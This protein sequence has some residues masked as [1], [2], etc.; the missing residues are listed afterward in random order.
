MSACL[1]ICT[2]YS[3]TCRLVEMQSCLFIRIIQE[4]LLTLV[5][6]RICPA[7]RYTDEWKPLDYCTGIRH[8]YCDLSSLIH[9][10]NMGYKVKVQLVVG[11]QAS[12]WIWKKFLPNTSMCG[13]K[14]A[15]KTPT[16]WLVE[17]LSF[18]FTLHL[19]CRQ[20]TAPNLCFMAYVQLSDS[21]CL[22]KTHFTQTLSFRGHLQRLPGAE[23]RRQKGDYKQC[24][25]AHETDIPRRGLIA[26]ETVQ[27]KP[28]A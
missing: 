21:F 17:L 3:F 24:M 23:R 1:Y 8:T 16:L 20:T 9:E 28:V 27:L 19:C 7:H 5:T 2:L 11:T 14:S 18:M 13:E 22:P 4:N 6:I 26:D 25:Q 12:A 10:Y 15:P